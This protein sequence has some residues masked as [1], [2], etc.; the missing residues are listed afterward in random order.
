MKTIPA[1]LNRKLERELQASFVAIQ[2]IRRIRRGSLVVHPDGTPGGRYCRGCGAI[3]IAA[4][5]QLCMSCET[6]KRAVR[7]DAAAAVVA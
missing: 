2:T 6:R 1:E 3:L 4:G 5:Q 7:R